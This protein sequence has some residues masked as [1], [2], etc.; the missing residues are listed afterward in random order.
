M[1]CSSMA[2]GRIRLT[3]CISAVQADVILSKIVWRFSARTTPSR[4]ACHSS[5]SQSATGR[6]RFII[7]YIAM[8]E[9][10]LCSIDRIFA[11]TL[12]TGVSLSWNIY[13]SNYLGASLHVAP[14]AG[15]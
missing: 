2:D 14:R 12:T 8:F 11:R 10:F 15:P 7:N 9:T 1:F 4:L 5:V 6:G 13:S 3:T